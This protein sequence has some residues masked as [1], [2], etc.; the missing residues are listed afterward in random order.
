MCGQKAENEV[1]QWIEKFDLDLLFLLLKD[2]D[3]S[4][5][6]RIFLD[7]SENVFWKFSH[8]FPFET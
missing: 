5:D 6:L 4:R 7:I 8:S 1:R 2:L 3:V